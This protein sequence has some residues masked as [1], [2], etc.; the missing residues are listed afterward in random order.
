VPLALAAVYRPGE[1][2][3][4]GSNGFAIAPQLTRNGYPLL[5]INPHTSFYLSEV[6]VSSEQGLNAYGAV[7]WGQFFVYQGFNDRLGWMHTSGG[8]DAIDEYLETVREQNGKFYYRYGQQWRALKP[9]DIRL[10]LQD[11]ARHGQQG[12]ACITATMAR[13]C[14]RWMA[15][16]WCA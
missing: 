8:G 14:G 11:G 15:N 16:G 13:S 6:Q 12:S 7:T 2:E 10:P 1:R 3:P 5:L 9:V 4:G